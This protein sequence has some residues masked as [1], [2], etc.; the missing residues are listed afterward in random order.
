MQKMPTTI[1][2]DSGKPGVASNAGG[3]V[4]GGFSRVSEIL[5]LVPLLE[6]FGVDMND[7]LREAGLPADQF[8]DP[9]NLIPFVEGSRFI[10]LCADHTCPHFGLLIGK[11]TSMESLGLVADLIRSAPDVRSAILLTVRY[12]TLTDGGGLTALSE[13]AHSAEW[14]YALYE[15][16]VERTEVLYDLG[17]TYCWNIMRTLC[18]ERWHPQEV[19]FTRSTPPDL[20]PYRAFFQAPLRFDCERS[21]L[22]FKRE[23]LDVPLP[24]SD[25][26]R[27]RA[28]E[29]QAREMERR[30]TGDLP[31]QIRRVLRRQLLSGSASM[32]K[33][34]AELAMHR[35]TL[36]R[37]L[38]EH[39]I[40][41]R[42]LVDEVRFDVSQQLLMTSLPVA[43]IAKSLQ[44]ASSAAFTRA[45]RR[46]SGSTPLHWRKQ[47]RAF[48]SAPLTGTTPRT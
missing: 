48:A 42:S 9:E 29:A 16:G 45:F 46:W 33:V 34:G 40:S 27:L 6:R 39:R 21:T 30:S 1:H 24:S 38:E 20:Q 41:F 15:P 28:L 35:R 13:S 7:L 32:E 3:V 37:R 44:Y 12:L 18:G 17:L 31:A 10:G 43:A 22:V 4:P 26:A 5:A 19:L 14:S 36:D 2:S 47:A 8:D 23:W 25:P 11:Y